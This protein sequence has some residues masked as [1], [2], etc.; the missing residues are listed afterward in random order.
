MFLPVMPPGRY[1]G[2]SDYAR[3]PSDTLHAGAYLLRSFHVPAVEPDGLKRVALGEPTL[4]ECRNRRDALVRFSIEALTYGCDDNTVPSVRADTTYDT[5]SRCRNQSQAVPGLP[6]L[7]G[8]LSMPTL[9]IVGSQTIVRFGSLAA[10]SAT[11][12]LKKTSP[13]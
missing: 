10:V 13:K 11:R 1:H 3:S 12:M 7:Q 6:L 8:T 4:V 5:R 2:N 9:W